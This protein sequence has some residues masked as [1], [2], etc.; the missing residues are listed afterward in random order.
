MKYYLFILLFTTTIHQTVCSQYLNQSN[1]MVYVDTN[2]TLLYSGE[3]T[4]NYENGSVKNKWIYKNGIIDGESIL[5]YEN[6]GVFHK[7]YYKNGTPQGE[8]IQYY[9]NGTINIIYLSFNH[10]NSFGTI[11]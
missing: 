4:T 10:F 3:L 1:R 11:T 5:F 2:Y 7:C 8:S 9:E 6:G